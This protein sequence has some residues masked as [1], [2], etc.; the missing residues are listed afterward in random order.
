MNFVNLKYVNTRRYYARNG[1]EL[2]DF[3]SIFDR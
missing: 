3:I 1:L 2:N